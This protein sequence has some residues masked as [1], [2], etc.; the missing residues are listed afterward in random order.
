M[1]SRGEGFGLVYLEAM[2]EGKPCIASTDD[3]ACE[4]VIGG[5]TGL[6]VRYGDRPGLARVLVELLGDADKRHR[7][8]QGGRDRLREHFTEEHF[9]L[10]LWNALS[11]FA[12]DLCRT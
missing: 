1:P 11:A 10:R 8:G 3:A 9:G 4:V 5:E 12:P 2:A 6:L 7:L